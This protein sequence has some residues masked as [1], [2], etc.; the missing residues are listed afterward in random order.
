V[1]IWSK[2]EFISHFS[3]G[4]DFLVSLSPSR[5]NGSYV[6]ITSEKINK[7]QDKRAGGRTFKIPFSRKI[8]N[9]EWG[10]Y[11]RNVFLEHR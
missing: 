5:K 11:L 10:R 3:K 8:K 9:I 6:M 2:D 7:P 4:M 1:G